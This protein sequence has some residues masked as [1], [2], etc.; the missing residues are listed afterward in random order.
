M[1]LIGIEKSKEPYKWVATFKEKDG[2]TKTT[3]FGASG[4]LD[5]TIGATKEQ[6]DAYLSRHK[7]DLATKDPTRAGFLSYFILWNTPS[8]KRNIELY[9]QRFNL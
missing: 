8:M 5:Y 2:S 6:R 3:R 1:K 4:Y 7:K 9:K